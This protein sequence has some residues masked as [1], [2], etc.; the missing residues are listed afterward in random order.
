MKTFFIGAFVAAIL[1]TSCSAYRGVQT[2]DDTYFVSSPS[3]ARGGNAGSDDY[4]QANSNR[5]DGRYNQ[6]YSGYDDYASSDDRWLMMR[7]RNRSRWSVFDDYNYYS[8][9]NDFAY[10][11]L[12]GYGF[13]YYPYA[14][15]PG[16]G[17]GY[18]TGFY[19]PYYSF[20]LGLGYG[21]FGYGYFNNFYN[22]N[23][24]YNPYFYNSIVVNP[25]LNPAGYTT[26]RNFNLGGYNN[27]NYSANTRSSARPNYNG[28]VAPANA[29][30]RVYYNNSGS[31]RNS[32]NNRRNNYSNNNNS[33]NNYNGGYNRSYDNNRPV[34]SYTPSNN[35]YTPS[36]SSNYSGGSNSG[37]YSGGNSGGGAAG[38]RPVR[39]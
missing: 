25:K 9:Y 4:V 37:G 38:S 22:W 32:G 1:F 6:S 24:V 33:N 14:Y 18:G 26:V 19:D 8:P 23:S 15:S 28:Y 3:V 7:V 13:G 31:N 36:R 20:G 21:G 12:G 30:S 2:P 27:R 29:P 10:G 5:N 16:F 34:R 39:R 17:L 11:G 35:S